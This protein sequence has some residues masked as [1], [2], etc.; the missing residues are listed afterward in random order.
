MPKDSYPVR[1]VG[2]QAVVTLPEHI[3]VS[4]AELRRTRHRS[5]P[6]GGH[7][8]AVLLK[9]YAHCIDGQA[10][11]ASKRIADALGGTDDG[12]DNHGQDG[13]AS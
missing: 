7:S 4:N 1:W 6:R 5:R 12:P 11:A 3:D 2:R 13:Q 10:E 8:V 9:I